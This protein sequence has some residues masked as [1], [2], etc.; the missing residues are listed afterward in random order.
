MK[1]LIPFMKRSLMTLLLVSSAILAF[2]ANEKRDVSQVTEAVTITEAIDYRI[3]H[4]TEPFTTAGS[5]DIAS[6]EHAVLIITD[7]KPSVVIKKWLSHVYINGEKAVDGEN[8]QVK[9]YGRGAI[10]F[11]Y[12]KDIRPLTCYTEQNFEGET[13]N[14]YTEGHS[15]GFM[16]TL[17]ATTLN[18]QIRSFKLKRGYMV[19]FAIG[20]GGWGYSRC[21]IA[22]QEDLEIKTLPSILDHRISSYRLF[23]W[24]NAHKAGLAS[25]GSWSE[26]QALNT[27]WCY[28]WAQGN[29]SNL[30]D[31]EWVPNHIYEDWPSS[32]TCG[33]VDGSC[34]MKTNNEPKN[35]ADDHPQDLPEILNNWQNLMRTGMRLCTPSSWDGSDY[36]NGT[37]FI[38]QFLDSIDARGWRCDIVDAHGYWPEGNFNHLKDYWYPNM[39]RPIWISEWIWGASWNGNGAFG[40]GVTDAQTLAATKRILNNLNSM[41]CVER[42][43][44]W[45]GESK[46]H[47]YRNG[48]L[49]ELGKYYATMDVGLGYNPAYEFIPKETRLESLSEIKST[50]NSRKGTVALSW[51]DPNC[52]LMNEINVQCKLPGESTFKTIATIQPK[53]K[54]GNG[55]ASYGYTDTVSVSGVHTYR[56]QAVAHNNKR[57]TSEDVIVNVAPSKGNDFIQYGNLIISNTEKIQVDFATTFSEAPSVFMGTVSNK[58]GTVYPTNYISGVTT[59]K[60]SYQLLPLKYQDDGTTELT[61]DEDIDFMAMLPGNHTFGNMDIEV[62]EASVKSDTLEVKFNKPF[63]ADVTPVVI[64]ELRAKAATS[65]YYTKIWDVTNE[66]FKAT[67]FYEIGKGSSVRLNQPLFYA[68]FTPGSEVIDEENGIVLSAGL[69]Q[70]QLYGGSARQVYFTIPRQENGVTVEDSL[71]FKSPYIFTTL[72]TYNYPA[73]TI[74]RNFSDITKDIDGVEYVEGLRIRRITDSGATATNNKASSDYAGWVTISTKAGTPTNIENVV[75]SKSENP[76]EV[77]VINRII[78]VKGYNDFELYTISGTKVASNATQTPGIYIVRAGDKTAKVVVK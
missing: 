26:N 38:A 60:F 17:N 22:D 45:N 6:T 41:G 15:G 44:Y 20:A 33:S 75:V 19:T 16:I 29:S 11:P 63:P 48:G 39:K 31:T 10:I 54:N 35:G 78:R 59:S 69:S 53:D 64:A 52:D 37:G 70:T 58:N 7:I 66:G 2:A 40:D 24:F 47:I 25:T 21:F 3:T 51:S 49:T 67:T 42:Y 74:L 46:G 50:Y 32:A 77:E 13:C 18:N 72:Q 36:W 61:K 9:M 14:N 5:V 27:S 65:T 62:G 56:I 8:C 55:G 30:P 73:G 43:A 4:S 28:D 1:K 68:A 34:H 71:I 23:K 57:V 12:G 76:L